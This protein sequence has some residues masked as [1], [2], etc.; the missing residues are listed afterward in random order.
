MERQRFLSACAGAMCV[1]AVGAAVRDASV[2]G[3]S[4]GAAR[5]TRAVSCPATALRGG[6]RD[7]EAVVAAVRHQMP[8]LFKGLTDMG[9]PV[10]INPGTYEIDGVIRLGFPPRPSFANGPALTGLEALQTAHR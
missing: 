9:E 6:H 8:I 10:P 7:I 1:V 2:A 5:S 4:T 3:A